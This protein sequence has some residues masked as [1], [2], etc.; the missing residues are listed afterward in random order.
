MTLGTQGGEGACIRNVHVGLSR[1][2]ATTATTATASATTLASSAAAT[3]T[4]A[5]GSM[6]G[7]INLDKDAFFL[8][9]SLLLGRGLFA[10]IKVGIV[11]FALEGNGVLPLRV[12]DALIGLAGFRKAEL[13]GDF[14]LAREIL[15]KGLDVRLGGRSSTG[16]WLARICRGR[17]VRRHGVK[18]TVMIKVRIKGI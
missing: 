18:S 3:T 11:V 7:L 17:I 6:P 5:L 14:G 8:V 1:A 9:L 2:T 4:A 13:V 16:S 15:V 10:H 12:V